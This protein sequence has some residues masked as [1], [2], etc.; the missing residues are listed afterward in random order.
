MDE[1][2]PIGELISGAAQDAGGWLGA[3]EVAQVA[4]GADGTIVRWNHVA[5]KLLGYAPPEVMGRH[6]ADLLHSGADRSLGRSLWETAATGR[7]VMGTVTAWHREGHPLELEIWACPVHS[8]RLGASAVL[9]FAADAHAAR[10]IRGSSAVWD[11]LFSRSPVG[12]AILD[13]HLRFLQV[14]PALEA[15]NGLPESAHV[16]RRLAELLPEVNAD[17][18]E[19]AMRQVLD[20]GEPVL[21]RRRVGRTPAD[22]EHDRV[23]SCS[24]VRV[25]DP[26]GRPIGVIASLLDITEQQRAQIEAEAGRRRLALLS[27]ASVRM[28]ASLELERTAQE[29]ADVAV[30]DLADAVTVDILDTLARGD[31]PG[32]GLGGG[33]AL[34]RLGK[35]PLTG[36]T[37]TDILAPL[38]RTLTFPAAAPYT[39]ALAARQPFLIARLDER[40]IAPAARHSTAPAQL[41]TAGV[42]SFMM[43]PLVARDLVLGVATFYRTR[44]VGPFGSDDVT[45]ASELAARAAVSIDNARLYHREHETAVVLQRSMLPQHITPPPGIE[46]AHRYLPA[47]D[48][49]EVG[50]D[51]YD[52]LHL[53]DDKAALLIGDVMGH[54]IAAAA[55]MGRLSATVRALARLDMPPTE[56]L[57]QLE[58]TLA[59]LAEPMLATF[60]YAVCDPVTGRC[61]ITRA[62]HPP[63]AAAAP[64]GTVRLLKTPPGVPLGVGGIDFTTTDVTLPPGSVLVLYTDGLIESRGRD[65]DE[66]LTDLTRLLTE[67]QRPLDHLCDSLITRLVPASA[68]D[69][70]ALLTARIG[71]T[72]GPYP[73]DRPG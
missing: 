46:V 67:P 4:T 72:L 45:L 50:G 69:D 28:G 73:T 61:T 49:N 42:H 34:R 5:E 6:I 14:N 55:V 59:D 32:M 3:L 40:A 10:R 21:D 20:T 22:P 30:P 65:I 64:D 54:G 41:L 2:T 52:V 63:P 47:S 1:Q 13:T 62:G 71:T 39:Q 43:V 31:E 56:L 35:A 19:E 15:M 17:E 24:Y 7:G 16:G 11:G 57:H 60:L 27:E 36:S 38:G 25:E 33:V 53:P 18:M 29:L 12:I 51:W 66:R 26:G 68:D 48:V 23:W 58:A 70:I 37:I 8:G 44:P 9:V